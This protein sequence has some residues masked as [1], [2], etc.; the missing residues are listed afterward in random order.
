LSAELHL[1]CTEIGHQKPQSEKQ[2]V[3]DQNVES[4][5]A[6]FID[7]KPENIISELRHR[8]SEERY[9]DGNKE[10]FAGQQLQVDPPTPT[11]LPDRHWREG[12]VVMDAS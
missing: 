8:D 1:I 6:K 2:K 11:V 10:V 9:Y 12:L 4:A 3:I 7:D 5:I